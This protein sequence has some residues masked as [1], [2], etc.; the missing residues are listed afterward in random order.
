MPD[1]VVTPALTSTVSATTTWSPASLSAAAAHRC[2]AARVDLGS[3]SVFRVARD[4]DG[5]RGLMA[6]GVER[7]DRA[8]SS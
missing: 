4:R 6:L 3:T 2:A 5:S 1:M 8:R 7:G